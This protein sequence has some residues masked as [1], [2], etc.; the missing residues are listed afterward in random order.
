MEDG[1]DMLQETLLRAWRRLDSYEGRASFRAWL[2]KIATNVCLDAL[3]RQRARSLPSLAG[4]PPS[5][6]DPLP[7]PAAGAGVAGAAARQPAGHGGY[8]SGDGLTTRAKSVSLAF[9]AGAAATAGPP[10]GGADPA[11]RAGFQRAGDG[12]NLGR[13]CGG[14][15]SA[16]QRARATMRAG[17]PART[18][19]RP[20]PKSPSCWRA[21]CRPGRWPTRPGWSRCCARTRCCRCRRPGLVPWAGRYRRV[22][23]GAC[24][25]R[26]RASGRY[27][28][29]ATH[30][31]GAPACGVYQLGEN[32][33]LRAGGAECARDSRRPD[34]L[35]CTISWP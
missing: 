4:P 8:G 29:L 31:N 18:A 12:P 14:V 28:L 30:A 25:L 16:L 17:R 20:R 35:R 34:R 26:G 24:R 32:G 2:Y 13:D 23:T 33:R 6:G 11:R 19:S 9:L 21:T 10:A 22:P 7:P 3:D 15:T 5:R 1:E 27:K